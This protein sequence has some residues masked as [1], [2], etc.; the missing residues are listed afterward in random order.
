MRH[1][2]TIAV[3]RATESQCSGRLTRQTP[4]AKRGSAMYLTAFNR[5]RRS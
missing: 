1:A 3:A 2:R 4:I 5:A